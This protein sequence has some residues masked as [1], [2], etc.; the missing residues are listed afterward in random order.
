[1]FKKYVPGPVLGLAFKTSVKVPTV[2]S[3]VCKHSSL[4]LPETLEGSSGG[5]GRLKP[6][7]LNWK[8]WIE[9]LDVLVI[10]YH[11]VIKHKVEIAGGGKWGVD[12]YTI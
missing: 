11:A 5:S 8:T 10:K 6:F 12:M 4:L 9:L 2:Y 7:L 3:G 1:M